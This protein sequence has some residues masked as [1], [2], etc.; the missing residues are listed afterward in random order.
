MKKIFSLVIGVLLLNSCATIVS[1]ANYTAKVVIENSDSAAIIVDDEIKGYGTADFK[2]KRANADNLTITVVEDGYKSQTVC[3]N[4]KAFNA[5][6][7]LGNIISWEIPGMAVDLVTGAMY[8]PDE[9]ER[10]I[11]KMS[12]N[13]FLYKIPYKREAIKE[14]HPENQEIKP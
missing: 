4:R 7:F 6:P 9:T 8:Q 13:V 2:W 11:K 14:E 5:L 12:N 10:G 3:F 1:T